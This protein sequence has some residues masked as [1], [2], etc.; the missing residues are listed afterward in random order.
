MS[1]QLIQTE[2]LGILAIR[3]IVS[4]CAAILAV[5]GIY[6]DPADEVMHNYCGWVIVLSVGNFITSELTLKAKCVDIQRCRLYAEFACA[7]C[8]L[9]VFIGFLGLLTT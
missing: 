4:L 8:Y 5:I 3:F 9:S 6:S 2:F 7:F 1:N